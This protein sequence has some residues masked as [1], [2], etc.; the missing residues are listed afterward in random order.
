VWIKATIL[1]SIAS[2]T[3]GFYAGIRWEKGVQVDNLKS[4]ITALSEQAER[5]LTNLNNKWKRE[6]AQVQ[7][8]L[9]RW[10]E[11]NQDDETLLREL[12]QGQNDIR[13]KFNDLGNEITITTDFGTCEL[14]PAAVEL[15]RN[16]S[17]SAATGDGESGD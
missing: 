10:H 4:Q 5:A 6:V 16:A 11:Q 13:E 14:S 3:L 17:R 9:D 8:D 15:L 7:L 1:A 2:L 12:L